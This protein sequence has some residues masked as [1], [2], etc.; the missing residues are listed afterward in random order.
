M[1]RFFAMTR[2]VLLPA[3]GRLALIGACL[4]VVAGCGLSSAVAQ[5]LG[6]KDPQGLSASPASLSMGP[7]DTGSVDAIE[8]G[9]SGGYTAT[10]SDSS[11]ATVAS[12]GP[13]QFIV[14]GVNVGTCTVTVSDSKGN[15]AT[16]SVSI[17]TTVIGGQ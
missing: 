4:F 13:A 15:D 1:I 17:Q 12:N 6:S 2:T 16:V 5:K 8:Q 10:S 7:T 3:L 11:V 14:T 9:Y